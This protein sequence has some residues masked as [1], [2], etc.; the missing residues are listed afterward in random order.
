MHVGGFGVR[1]QGIYRLLLVISLFY[2]LKKEVEPEN[3]Y[4]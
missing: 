3:I 4:I 2:G 1:L